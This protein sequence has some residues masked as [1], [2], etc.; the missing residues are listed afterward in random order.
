MESH[1][2]ASAAS[3]AGYFKEQI[4]GIDIK[5]RKGATVFHTDF[6]DAHLRRRLERMRLTA[7]PL[8]A[9]VRLSF[10]CQQIAELLWIGDDGPAALQFNETASMPV[11]QTTVDVLAGGADHFGQLGLRQ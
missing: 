6:T 5:S 8:P 2:C 11:S 1:R 3:K 9:E 10:S 7:K 4:L